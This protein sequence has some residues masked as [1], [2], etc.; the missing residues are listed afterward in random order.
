[1]TT[2]EVEA[3]TCDACGARA[4]LYAEHDDWP[5]GLAYCAHHGTKYLAELTACGARI[6][7][8]RHMVTP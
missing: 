4:F 3:D 8:L 5:I 2:V 1:M 7:D 6:V